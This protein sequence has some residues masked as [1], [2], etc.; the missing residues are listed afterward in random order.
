MEGGAKHMA[1]KRKA[2]HTVYRAK[3][4]NTNRGK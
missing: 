1:R 3:K 4:R 2:A